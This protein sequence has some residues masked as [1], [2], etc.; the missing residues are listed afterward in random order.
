[1]HDVGKELR[2]SGKEIVEKGLDGLAEVGER[3]GGAV[4]GV[5]EGTGLAGE[6]PVEGVEMPNL[7]DNGEDE[8]PEAA[9]VVSFSW[10][11]KEKAACRERE[12]EHELTFLPISLRRA[13]P[14]SF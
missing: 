14:I 11:S 2:D 4:G 8:E 12:N 6:E 13:R 7:Q 1:V 5:G 9:E 10:I 3:L